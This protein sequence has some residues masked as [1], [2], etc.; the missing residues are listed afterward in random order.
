[1]KSTKDWRCS[2]RK[3]YLEVFSFAFHLFKVWL[4]YGW[5]AVLWELLLDHRVTP[6]CTYTLMGKRRARMEF[7]RTSQPILW[8]RAEATSPFRHMRETMYTFS[9][10]MSAFCLWTMFCIYIFQISRAIWASKLAR[11]L[12]ERSL[13]SDPFLLSLETHQIPCPAPAPK[14]G[15]SLVS[16]IYLYIKKTRS[17]LNNM[18]LLFILGEWNCRQFI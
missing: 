10:K 14:Q 13:L 16:C 11:S 4:K 17:N 1:M 12:E 9:M 3:S 7:S 5:F 2:K 6:F 15:S 18:Y 8:G